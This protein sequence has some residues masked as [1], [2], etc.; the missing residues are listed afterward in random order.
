MKSSR[1]M[2]GV[3]FAL[4]VLLGSAIAQTGAVRVTVPFDFTIGK[5]AMAAGD[6]KVSVSGSLLEVARIDGPGT[7]T[8]STNLT[9]GGSNQN[10]S[11]R[12]VFHCYGNHRFLSM[13]W[14]GE[15]NQGHELYA[16][17][18][19]LELARTTKQDEKVVL[20]SR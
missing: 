13:A 9:G 15:V 4:S 12:L 7:A 6:Y 1:F 16:S 5:Q 18:A 17:P 10:V 3:A 19:E 2:I 14:I 8:V 11:P 20:A